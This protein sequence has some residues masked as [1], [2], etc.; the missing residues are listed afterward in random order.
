MDG[1]ASAGLQL[2]NEVRRSCRGGR[3]SHHFVAAAT[4]VGGE[5]SLIVF[6]ARCHMALH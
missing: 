6:R 1:I 2:V 3:A 5:S 4:I